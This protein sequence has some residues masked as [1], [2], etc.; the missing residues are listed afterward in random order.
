MEAKGGCTGTGIVSETMRIF[1][2][3]VGRVVFFCSIL[4][5]LKLPRTD[6]GIGRRAPHKDQGPRGNVENVFVFE[7]GR[8]FSQDVGE[9]LTVKERDGYAGWK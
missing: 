9:E 1:E 7:E 5:G 3:S 2:C 4:M 8:G 6:S